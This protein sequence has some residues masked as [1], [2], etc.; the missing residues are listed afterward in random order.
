MYV[1]YLLI[2]LFFNENGRGEGVV[3]KKLK[4]MIKQQTGSHYI[5]IFFVLRRVFSVPL[6]VCN[7]N[8]YLQV[9]KQCNITTNKCN[10]DMKRQYL[11][12]KH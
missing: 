2:L 5:S 7:F 11:V 3:V 10:T 12:L 8:K 4:K 1:K 9:L 6:T